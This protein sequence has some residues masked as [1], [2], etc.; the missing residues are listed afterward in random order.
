MIELSI[1]LV[2]FEFVSGS[3][4]ERYANFSS[5]CY[6]CLPSQKNLAD[7]LCVDVCP[8]G[9]FEY[10]SCSGTKFC[11]TPQGSIF[12]IDISHSKDSVQTFT[13][14]SDLFIDNGLPKLP[15][16]QNNNLFYFESN[17]T[18]E[19]SENYIPS[20]SFSFNLWI[21]PLDQG[22]IIRVESSIGSHIK[23]EAR[24]NIYIF[25][26]TVSNLLNKDALEEIF[27]ETSPYQNLWQALS[28]QFEQVN[29]NI[30]ELM[31]KINDEISV[32]SF[33]N[34]E[35]S[36][37]NELYKWTIGSVD[38]VSSFK[39]FIYWLEARNNL[40]VN[41]PQLFSKLEYSENSYRGEFSCKN[42]VPVYLPEPK[43]SQTNHSRKLQSCFTG[44]L[45]CSSSL[46]N[47][48]TSCNP[49]LVQFN[50]FCLNDCPTGKSLSSI[51]C[52]G[53][54]LGFGFDLTNSLI[55]SQIGVWDIGN[56]NANIYPNFDVNDPK[57]AINRGYYFKVS[58]RIS[59][60][61][62]IAPSFALSL[63]L[64]I[65]NSG[66]ILVKSSMSDYLVVKE[67]S[68]IIEVS[69]LMTDGIPYVSTS[70]NVCKQWCNLEISAEPGALGSTLIR[71]FIN[72]S[73]SSIQNAMMAA[74]FDS[75]NAGLYVGSDVNYSNGFEGFI[76]KLQIYQDSSY[77]G[78]DIHYT[79]TGT[80]SEC[81]SNSL[82]LS[83]CGFTKFPEDCDTCDFSCTEGCKSS[84]AC[85]LCK[86]KEC[87]ECSS[88]TN[89]CI[90]C[91]TN[92]EFV[93]TDCKCKSGFGW[94]SNSQSCKAC[95]VLNCD[96]CVD[97]NTVCT[98]CYSPYF[99]IKNVCIT[100]CPTGYTASNG[101]CIQDSALNGFVF[102]L[103]P[104]KIE[105]V[106]YDLQSNIPVVTGVNNEF[107]P[108]YD[109]TDPYAAI[110]RGYYFT[111]SSLMMAPPN[112]NNASP[113]LTISP[114]FTILMWYYPINDGWIFSKQD[115]SR[116][117]HIAVGV[118]SK[119]PAI[120]MRLQDGSA[121]LMPGPT[122]ITLSQWSFT[123]FYSTTDW[124]N[125][126]I[127][128]N[129]NTNIDDWS[130]ISGAFF[131]DL[132][133]SFTILFGAKYDSSG[134]F[135]EFFN[136]FL[137]EFKI[138]NKIPTELLYSSCTYLSGTSS[139]CPLELSGNCIPDCSID[140]YPDN[141]SCSD[142][143]ANCLSGCK[144]NGSCNL[145]MDPLCYKCNDYGSGCNLCKDN[146]SLSI[147]SCICDF[148]YIYE[149]NSER[150]MQTTT[151][152]SCDISCTTCSDAYYNSC[153]TCASN[154]YSFA[155][156]CLRYC[157]RGYYA[158]SY[159]TCQLI[160]SIIFEL[161]LNTLN[162]VVYD[163]KYLIPAITGSTQNFYKNYDLDDPL[164][165]Y[166][167][168]FYFNGISSLLNL[169]DFGSY[170]S[171]VLLIGP[172]FTFSLWINPESNNSVLFSKKNNSLS[173]YLSISLSNGYPKVLINLAHG[174][175]FSFTC[176]SSL[177]LFQWNHLAIVSDYDG[178]NTVITCIVNT[179]QNSNGNSPGYFNDISTNMRV[180][181]GS[182]SSSLTS[183]SSYYKG[184]IY[185][186]HIYSIANYNTDLSIAS[187]TEDCLSCPLSHN[188]IPNCP[189]YEYWLGPSYKS[190]TDCSSSCLTCKDESLLC[191]LC[192]NKIC[193]ICN[194]YSEDSCLSCIEN[195]HNPE[196][197]ICNENYGWNSTYE[198]C[199]EITGH[200]TGTDGNLYPCPDLC[201]ACSSSNLCAACVENA[202]IVD[203]LCK[204]NDG[205]RSDSQSCTKMLFS[206]YLSVKK[207]NSLV[208]TFSE[209]LST[210]IS[211]S[212]INIFINA[213]NIAFT[214]E[215]SSL[216]TF[217][218]TIKI[219]DHITKGTEVI[220]HFID[221]IHIRS[222]QR[223]Y[224][225][226]N[227][228]NGIL[229]E[230]YPDTSSDD[231]NSIILQTTAT[232]QSAVSASLVLAL[233]SGNL[234]SFWNFLNFLTL[235]SY[236]P[237]SGIDF[238]QKIRY[239]FQNLL[240]FNLFPNIFEWFVDENNGGKP[241]KN[242]YEAG[243]ET[244]L[245]FLNS[246]SDFTAILLLIIAI[247]FV[248]YFS[249]C[250]CKYIAQKI[251]K[252]LK[253]Y[254]FAIF[255]RFWIQIYLEIGISSLI[256]LTT[257]ENWN[258]VQYFNKVLSVI[259]TLF[260]F[261]TPILFPIFCWKN[262]G[263]I[264]GRDKSFLSIWDPFFYEFKND[265][266][267]MSTQ[268]YTVFFLRRLVYIFTLIILKDYPSAE[269]TI[270]IVHSLL[271]TLYL[272]RYWPYN[273]IL[274]QVGNLIAEIGIVIVMCFTGAF[275][276]DM[277]HNALVNIEYAIIWTVN[278]IIAVNLICSTIISVRDI[279]KIIKDNFIP[280]KNTEI[281]K[282]I[283]TLGNATV[284]NEAIT[285]EG[286]GASKIV[287]GRLK[288]GL[289]NKMK[290]ITI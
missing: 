277:D 242:A 202:I 106:V 36:F 261:I 135:A 166:L 90:S 37:P 59:T 232:V 129:T 195:A 69:I 268:F 26:L 188:C 38:E 96:L 68:D 143:S 286:V 28:F 74:F 179:I 262:E 165:A 258:I 252:I 169:P 254:K 40:E 47:D 119:Q 66:F 123:I 7:R 186:I 8:T 180:T 63:W 173:S 204:C 101:A 210:N 155:G 274:V 244:D 70:T 211:T 81:P 56:N 64:K 150:C 198:N 55:L 3:C 284:T 53:P 120:S 39:G 88:Y 183:G 122:T 44:C 4:P 233:L 193:N 95:E 137:W 86:N 57:P 157:P 248:Y 170:T 29:C 154:H 181:I 65:I 208:L 229:F 71:I 264:I 269:V 162:G 30:I 209:E 256:C 125:E 10:S 147:G 236:L 23:I 15:I 279:W 224:L 45:A 124:N 151:T 230:Y 220:L 102:D 48:C 87:Y 76:S 282:D 158:D 148:G 201:L 265:Q 98:K 111:G 239:F 168:G 251:E 235:L 100:F 213:K 110:E 178:S 289:K 21:K 61:G 19:S 287:E 16:L 253:S 174:A 212:D 33:L 113:L 200:Y 227:N 34:V 288:K 43:S 72:G 20:F 139:F 114:E 46:F 273:D 89:T 9:S 196:N 83:E 50:Y 91:K 130:G 176:Q 80:C 280:K 77:V 234:S 60:S 271:N 149:A 237:L 182:D 275:L 22:N 246:G 197:C 131:V 225:I 93:G 160:D 42:C 214:M 249:N 191:N 13:R 255:L 31:V 121:Y 1:I 84:G 11:S 167:R 207:D 6:I 54:D 5:S 206:A 221:N 18:I 132:E 117:I 67:D 172:I 103:K 52:I 133:S 145:C 138:Y 278:S 27:I 141:G 58:D 272:I 283:N 231:A 109:A 105:D 163:K 290:V 205:Y 75:I 79:C 140:D 175:L 85:S 107:Y 128:I 215:S 250:S 127:F 270:N 112:W 190:C 245:L 82:C 194:D 146:A 240:S 32:R 12:T 35:I 62:V 126:N 171:P 184:F 219:D 152:I 78:S 94:Y 260:L 222:K 238:S 226:T 199:N 217:Y 218:I 115:L 156:L 25:I 192:S 17:K 97:D 243:F 118:S 2:L 161:D 144:Q 216:A 263:H 51:Q 164:P 41:F 189:I 223:A 142:C 285:L 276:F 92:A 159:E 134:N 14:D 136:G 241:Y 259:L 257:Y 177:S 187:C 108:N 104:L 228:L 73:Q 185:H 153:I 247:P 24:E 267:F 99:Y 281:N 266:G 49:G 116:N 203:G